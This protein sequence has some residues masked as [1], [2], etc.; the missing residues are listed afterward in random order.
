MRI[1]AAF[2]PVGN[3]RDLGDF[4][5]NSGECGGNAT[6]QGFAAGIYV[7]WVVELSGIEPLTSSLRTTRS[8][9]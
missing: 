4:A 9:N 5:R 6:R 3:R 7:G 8:P 1:G 2:R